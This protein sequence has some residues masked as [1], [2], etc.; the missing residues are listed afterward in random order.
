ME[1]LECHR[2]GEECLEYY[3]K[4]N[5]WNVTGKMKNV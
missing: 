2:E 1:S 3:L 5:H 4:W